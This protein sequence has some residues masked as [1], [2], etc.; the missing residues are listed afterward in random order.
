MYQEERPHLKPLPVTGEPYF[1]EVTRQES[2]S[3][4]LYKIGLFNGKLKTPSEKIR[5]GFLKQPSV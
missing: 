1:A 4:C 2:V 3:V 5:A